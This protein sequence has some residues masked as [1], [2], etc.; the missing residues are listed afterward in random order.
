[1]L[2]FDVNKMFGIEGFCFIFSDFDFWLVVKNLFIIVG[3]MLFIL[4][5]FGGIFVFLMVCI[6]LFGCCWFE[7]LL[8]MLVFVLLMVF[9]FGYVVVVG[10]VG[11][12][13]VWFKELFGV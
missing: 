12:Y 1:M 10:L 6:D 8:F 5:L 13:L 4:I 7:L 11:F 3:G 2:F 9:V